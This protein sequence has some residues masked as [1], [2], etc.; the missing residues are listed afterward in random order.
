MTSSCP[1]IYDFYSYSNFT[2]TSMFFA[3]GVTLLS[4]AK[5]GPCGHAEKGTVLYSSNTYSWE[6]SIYRNVLSICM[7]LLVYCIQAVFSYATH[8]LQNQDTLE[9]TRIWTGIIGHIWI[10]ASYFQPDSL[11]SDSLLMH[12]RRSQH[13]QS[14]PLSCTYGFACGCGFLRRSAGL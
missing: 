7:L 1:H 14:T 3:S 4:H 9:G 12:V 11:T 13:A 8:M 2:R 10:S 5:Y 6:S